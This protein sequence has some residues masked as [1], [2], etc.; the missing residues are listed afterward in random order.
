MFRR[1]HVGPAARIHQASV[2]LK[3]YTVGGHWARTGRGDGPHRLLT[4]RGS[5]VS[6]GKRAFTSLWQRVSLV[7]LPLCLLLGNPECPYKLRSV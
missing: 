7:P 4:L 5:A 6:V 3:L 1:S 2:P